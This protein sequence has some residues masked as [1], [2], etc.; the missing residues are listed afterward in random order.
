MK[1]VDAVF[2]DKTPGQGPELDPAIKTL[3]QLAKRLS[4]YAGGDAPAAEG[5]DGAE[6]ATGGGAAPAAAAPVAGA[7]GVIN[8]PTDVSNAIDR[9]ITY[10]ERNEPSSPVPLM[11][12]RAK[13]LVNADFL[14]IMKDMA[15]QGVDNVN[16][17][18]GIEDD[19]Y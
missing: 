18:G 17:I 6:A 8:S 11:L 12:Q 7:P 1:A 14:T 10:Y 13:R 15:P 4:G 9:I 3:Q 2:A 16:L 19:E 5:A